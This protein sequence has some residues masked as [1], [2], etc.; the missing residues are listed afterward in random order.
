M[1]DV[2]NTNCRYSA[3]IVPYMYGELASAETASFESHLRECT[4]CTD[5]FA[6]ISGAR[7]EVYDWKKLEF[8]PLPTP[9]VRVPFGEVATVGWVERFQAVFARSRAV[10]GFAFAGIAVV[11]AFA[12]VFLLNS[13]DGSP[14]QLA[15]N[16]SR[17]PV[18]A[19]PENQTPT[20]L[21]TDSEIGTIAKPAS[22]RLNEA[23]R[24]P[25]SQPRRAVR[26]IRRAGP[27]PAEPRMTTAAS[28][29]RAA[30]RLNEFSD[31]ED[32]SLRLAELF[33][34]VETSD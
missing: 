34:D 28:R 26:E 19:Q 18:V 31:E 6:A 22:G 27:R 17:D 1:K 10:P 3:D 12:A 11:A 9:P 2:N 33:E 8:D 32:N 7:Y 15:A 16:R 5:E 14:E 30:P 25:V 20:V 4:G 29:N 24:P 21:I 23:D 13:Q